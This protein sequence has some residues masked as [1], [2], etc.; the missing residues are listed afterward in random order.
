M[1]FYYKRSIAPNGLEKLKLEQTCINQS[2]DRIKSQSRMSCTDEVSQVNQ[3]SLANNIGKFAQWCL[4]ELACNPDI[5]HSYF[6]NQISGVSQLREAASRCGSI[7]QA[8]GELTSEL[9]KQEKF[10]VQWNQ[11]REIHLSGGNVDH[12]ENYCDELRKMF[13][14]VI[15]WYGYYEVEILHGDHQHDFREKLLELINFDQNILLEIVS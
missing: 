11:L 3:Q 15:K 5:R 6:S 2:G 12:E 14:L 13:D 10:R 4:L 1:L 7:D 8:I 9:I